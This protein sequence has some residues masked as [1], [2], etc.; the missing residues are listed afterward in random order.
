[1]SR[2]APTLSAE[3]IRHSVGLARALSAG[4]RNWSVYPSGHPAVDASTKR[5]AEAVRL[6]AAG[7]A[8]TFGATPETLLV[9]GVPLPEEQPVVE[10]A[11]LLHDHDLLQL[12]FLGEPPLEALHALLELLSTPADDLRRNGGPARAWEASGISSIVLEQID[13]EKILEDRDVEAPADRHD[14][15]WR[16][17][18]TSI[19]EGRGIFDEEQQQRLLVI[20][21]SAY[22]IGDLAGAVAAPKVSLDGSPLITTQAAT[23]LAVF[24]HLAGIVTVMD[25][26]RLP[27]VLRNVAAATSMLDPHVVVQLMQAEDDIQQMPIVS[28]IAASFDDDKV[29]Q[30]LATALAREGKATAR[31]A[32][33]FDTIAPDDARKRRVL[34]MAQTMLSE[35]DFGRSGQFRAV[36]SSM[37]TLLLNYD[38]T[39]F[40]SGSYQAS[41]DAAT[42][43]GAMLAARD[44][45]AELSEWVDTLGEDNVRTLSV[46]L[47]TDLLHLEEDPERATEITRDMVALVDDLLMAGDFSNAV[48]VLRQLRRAAAAKI[49]PAEARAALSSSGESAGLREAAALMNDLDEQAQQTFAECC[50]LVGPTSIRALYPLLKSE[51]DA[52][53]YRQA[54]DI[55]HKFGAAAVPHLAGLADDPQ[56]FVQRNSAILLGATRSRDAVA[57]LQALLRRGDPRVVRPAVSALAG[58][59]DPAAARAI[60]TVLRATAGATRAAVV[61]ALVAER[62]SRV[63]PMLA[64]IL[65]ETDP[66]GGD[67]DVVLDALNAVGQLAHEQAV[68][69][70]DTVMRRKK[71]LFGRAKARA[72]KTASVKALLA[73]G[74]AEAQ[75]AL[76]EAARTGDG[77]LKTVIRQA[78]KTI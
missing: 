53:T 46:A 18:V 32:Q 1:M 52:P 27:D 10:A 72:F 44:L 39:P 54:R 31:L 13:Y 19:V 28:R 33:V 63:V 43:R 74:T 40:V 57:P 71:F 76:D 35:Q 7:A 25:P 34:T 78:R 6:S 56:W 68:K 45:P 62:D 16:S 47:I 61:E 69:S 9:A 67:H 41:L 23:V 75:A 21:G 4:V 37:E 17:I 26:E 14:D 36:W 66:F 30:L 8:F 42:D 5:L 38:E 11:R 3:L 15:V 24:R 12:T 49:A 59:D 22:D 65:G 29:A 73:I 64:R 51:H 58:I 50:E 20:S 48:L 55:V 70:V 60:Q 77:L 2:P